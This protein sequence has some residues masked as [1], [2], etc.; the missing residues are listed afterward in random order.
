M[1]LC[2]W[3]SLAIGLENG[4]TKSTK[5]RQTK[6]MV[7][8][9]RLLI[10][11]AGGRSLSDFTLVKECQKCQVRTR[12]HRG[13]I[14]HDAEGAGPKCHIVAAYN[15]LRKSENRV[16]INYKLSLP[17]LIITWEGFNQL[18]VMTNIPQNILLHFRGHI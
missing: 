11:H 6:F 12:N 16:T 7:Y 17:D 4:I 5:A 9:H 14:L 10:L 15:F 18:L 2:L 1:T 3:Y 13:H 8:C